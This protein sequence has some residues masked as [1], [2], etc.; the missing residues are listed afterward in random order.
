VSPL[1]RCEQW[2]SAATV[3]GATR[4]AA[5]FRTTVGEPVAE[6]EASSRAALADRY[7]AAAA[8][9]ASMTDDELVTLMQAVAAELQRREP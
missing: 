5:L 3:E 1:A 6:A 4:A 9:G 7:D 2:E 8:R